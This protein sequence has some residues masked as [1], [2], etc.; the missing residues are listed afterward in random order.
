MRRILPSI[1]NLRAHIR[2]HILN[3]NPA[4]TPEKMTPMLKMGSKWSAIQNEHKNVIIMKLCG[5]AIS[6]IQSRTNALPDC[7]GVS[8]KSKVDNLLEENWA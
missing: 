1:F 3:D 6:M 2:T 8:K 7:L 4:N 5:A